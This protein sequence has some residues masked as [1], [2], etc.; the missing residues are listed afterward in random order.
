[1]ARF[2]IILLFIWDMFNHRDHEQLGRGKKASPTLLPP[3]T[4]SRVINAVFGSERRR[5]KASGP[6]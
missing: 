6:H 2:C 3:S 4:V 5:E 1:M